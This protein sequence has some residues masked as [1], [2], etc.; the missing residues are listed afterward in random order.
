MIL[1]LRWIALITITRFSKMLKTFVL[2]HPPSL[3]GWFS[4]EAIRE[5][6]SRN[7]LWFLNYIVENVLKDNCSSFSISQYFFER[8]YIYFNEAA[9]ATHMVLPILV[10]I[11]SV[12]QIKCYIDTFL[13]NTHTLDFENYTCNANLFFNTLSQKMRNFLFLENLMTWIF[14]AVPGWMP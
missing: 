13:N 12:M 10:M 1:C 5:R 6:F 8:P 7:N 14:H 11:P 2:N 9:A 3:R 4:A